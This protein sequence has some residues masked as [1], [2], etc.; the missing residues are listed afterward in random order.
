MHPVDEAC[1]ILVWDN[2]I[3]A[4]R[5]WVG[6][7]HGSWLGSDRRLWSGGVEGGKVQGRLGGRS[8]DGRERHVARRACA[9]GEG[10]GGCGVVVLAVQGARREQGELTSWGVST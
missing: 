7:G 3:S 6:M 9:W 1:H 10:E 2:K 8:G 4:E 5:E